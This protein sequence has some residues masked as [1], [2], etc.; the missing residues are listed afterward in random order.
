MEGPMARTGKIEAG[1]D[2]RRL[3]GQENRRRIVEAMLEL[4]RGGNI[5]PGAEDVSARANV[6][7]RTVFR[8]FDDMDS[9]YRELSEM[10]RAEIEPVMSRPWPEGG[11]PVRLD[12]IVERRAQVFEKIMPFQI[13]ADV[14]KHRSAFLREDHELLTRMQR[15]VLREALPPEMRKDRIAFE[16]L[17]LLLSFDAWRRLRLE[18]GLSVQQAKKTI[19]AATAAISAGRGK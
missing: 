4:V 6:G 16:A 3:R 13:A 2:G 15:A 1:T 14:H 11:W 7:L 18:Q 8:H 10:I 12:A 17:E 19:A 5:S 9:L